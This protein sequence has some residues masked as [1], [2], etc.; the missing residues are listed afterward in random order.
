MPH[1]EFIIQ[2]EGKDGLIGI[3]EDDGETG[4]FYLFDSNACGD[5]EGILAWTPV[6]RRSTLFSP[7]KSDI[8]IAWSINFN[9][10]AVIVKAESQGS[11]DCFRAVIDSRSKQSC[12]CFMKDAFAEPLRDPFWLSGFEW[13]WISNP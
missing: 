4:T 1:T 12:N 9:K 3:F 6:Y 13:T 11:Q 5:Q 7:T 8:W 10:V 2:E